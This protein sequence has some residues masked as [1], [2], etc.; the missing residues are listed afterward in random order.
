MKCAVMPPTASRVS[1]VYHCTSGFRS[2]SRI[3][4][5]WSL[6]LTYVRTVGGVEK[7]C[8]RMN[9]H[10]QVV[11]RGCT[12]MLLRCE[13]TRCWYNYTR[14]RREREQV[15]VLLRSHVQFLCFLLAL[16]SAS[17][18]Q[19]CMD[20]LHIYTSR[21]RRTNPSKHANASR[22]STCSYWAGLNSEETAVTHRDDSVTI[23]K[24]SSFQYSHFR[25]L[26]T[27]TWLYLKNKYILFVILN[28]SDGCR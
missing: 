5:C 21:E 4:T 2:A 23:Q 12:E 28:V 7:P 9:E 14:E 16:S 24:T 1:S 18:L 19:P 15:E 6:W 25:I 27:S 26:S 10:V 11:L 20:M 17:T 3:Q 22:P 13:S 8:G